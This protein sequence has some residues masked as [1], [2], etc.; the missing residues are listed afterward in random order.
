MDLPPVD[1]VAAAGEPY[2]V[3]HAGQDHPEGV[4]D[5]QPVEEGL[6][7]QVGLHPAIAQQDQLQHPGDEE[8][9]PV[10]PGGVGLLEDEA[11]GVERKPVETGA[12]EGD[13]GSL[14]EPAEPYAPARQAWRGGIVDQV[15]YP[16]VEHHG[17]PADVE[18]AP[19]GV[20]QLQQVPGGEDEPQGKGHENGRR[21]PAG[22]APQREDAQMVGDGRPGR[23]GEGAEEGEA[24]EHLEGH[25]LLRRDVDGSHQLD[26]DSPFR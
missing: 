14:E 19:L 21:H 3:H 10:P 22:L 6:A 5:T 2:H 11:D 7:G 9:D 24:G 1:A 18:R 13:S 25:Q 8:I 17:A 20:A 12:Q 15:G 23:D 16:V 26:E 4:G